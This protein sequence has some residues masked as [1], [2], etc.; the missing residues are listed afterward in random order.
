MSACLLKIGTIENDV[1]L[2]FEDWNNVLSTPSLD[3]RFH[4]EG[5][6]FDDGV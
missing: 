3:F 6:G 5:E 1:S 2:P 4:F